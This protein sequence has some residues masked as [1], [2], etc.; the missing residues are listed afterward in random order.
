MNVEE[1]LPSSQEAVK[2]QYVDVLSV[3]EPSLLGHYTLSIDK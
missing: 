2:G 3:P 1:S